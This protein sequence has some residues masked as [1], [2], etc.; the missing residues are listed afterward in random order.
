MK[1]AF[2]HN[3][4]RLGT[5]AHHIN[6]LMAVRLREAGVTVRN[7]YPRHPLMDAPVHLKGIANILFF[8]S[9]LERQDD[10]LKCDLIQ[11]TTYTPLAFLSFPIPVV[12]HFGSTSWGFLRAVPR[13]S[14][15]DDGL[16]SVW[17]E[18]KSAKVIKE[19]NVKTRKPLRDV[20]EVEKLVATQ[21]DAVI[22]TSDIVRD[23]LLSVGVPADRLHVVHNAIEDYWFDRRNLAVR[24][25]PALV[26][27]GRIGHDVFTMKLKGIDRLIDLYR[28][29][30]TLEKRTIGMTLNAS[31]V[32]W[33]DRNVPHHRFEQN[34]AKLDIPGRLRDLEGS[35]LFIPSR[36]EGFSLSLIEGMSRGLI[37][38]VYPVGIAPEIIVNGQ[39]GFLVKNQD[40]ARASVRFLMHQSPQERRGMAMHARDTARTFNAK[41]IVGSL[42]RVYR[43]VLADTASGTRRASK[44]T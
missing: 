43:S 4:K 5:G 38:V 7:F 20:A 31:L 1:V 13:T 37:P 32:A 17:V 9:L 10:I 26:F 21:A 19:L 44:K 25:A 30:P 41:R 27:L 39:N 23:D 29:F 3:S 18:L 40:E 35:V 14:D 6:D 11:G 8:H 28:S 33:M 24:D 2:I 34:V 12:S 36:Y 15:L 16:R 22:A 42:L